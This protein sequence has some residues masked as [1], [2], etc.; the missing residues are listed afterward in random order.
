MARPVRRFA[1]VSAEIRVLEKGRWGDFVEAAEVAFAEPIEDIEKDLWKTVLPS[2]RRLGAYDTGDLVGTAAS[3]PMELTVPGATVNAA[4]VTWVSVL[5]THRRQ[6]ALTGMMRHQLDAAHEAGESLAVLWA[7]ESG[8]YGRY[9]YGVAALDLTLRIERSKG[10]LEGPRA[11]HGLRLVDAD[12]VGQELGPVYDTVRLRRPG[13]FARDE[14][15]W[16]LRFIDTP[17]R[18]DGAGQLVFTVHDGPEGVDGYVAY[19]VKYESDWREDTA[20][21]RVS[22]LMAAT[23]EAYHELWRFVLELELTDSVIARHRPVDE[24]L[25]WMV[26]DGRRIDSARADNLWT[27]LVDVPAALAARRYRSEGSVVL[28]V[29]DAFCAW[30]EGRF[31]LRGGLEGAECTPTRADADLALGVADLGAVYLGGV[32]LH[33]LREAGRVE[34]RSP[35][36]VARADAM[37]GWDVAP[38]CPMVF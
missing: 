3:V 8:I 24:A 23:P 5:P 14:T 27:R 19:R 10:L 1:T 34:E 21:V 36:A 12:K 35:G 22:E 11:S 20:L 2:G 4:G 31:Q 28:E 7:S 16:R 15:W 38:W 13:M 25:P 6:G 32:P 18:R 33:T 37:F 17:E 29:R 26:R 9:G 30:N